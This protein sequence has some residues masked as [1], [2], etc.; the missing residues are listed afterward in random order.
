MKNTEIECL[1]I[2]KGHINLFEM[3]YGFIGG[4]TGLISKDKLAFVE[5]L[6]NILTMNV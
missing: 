6:K 2:E 5:M 3:N 4:C 1:L